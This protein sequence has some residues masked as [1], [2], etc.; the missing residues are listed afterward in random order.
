MGGVLPN[1]ASQGGGSGG[2]GNVTGPGSSTTNALARYS[3]ASGTTIKN[4]PVTVADDGTVTGALLS[5]AL[6][7]TGI[8]AI[9]RGGTGQ[10]TK[11]FVTPEQYGAIGDGSTDDSAAMQS[12]VDAG[13]LIILGPGKNYKIVTG[14][15]I[16][17]GG[18]TI[19]GSAVGGNNT[20]A[21]KSTIKYVGSGS[22]FASANPTTVSYPFITFENLIID[23]SGASGTN[24]VL[25]F[26]SC[27]FVTLNRV[28]FFGNGATNG[29]AVLHNVSSGKSSYYCTIKEC[30]F[31]THYIGVKYTNA[32]NSNVVQNTRFQP[33]AGGTGIWVVAANNISLVSNFFEGGSLGTNN[34]VLVDSSAVSVSIINSRFEGLANSIKI[35]A[36]AVNTYAAG[37]YYSGAAISDAGTASV[38]I[39]AGTA[40]AVQAG[41]TGQATLTNHGVLVGAGTAALTQ[42]AVGATKSV[43]QGTSGADP[44]FTTT[45]TVTSLTASGGP[46]TA[47]SAITGLAQF[48]GAGSALNNVLNGNTATMVVA[49]SNANALLLIEEGSTGHSCLVY[50]GFSTY[51]TIVAQDATTFNAGNLA[52]KIGLT[53]VSST[54]I[55]SINNQQGTTLN[56]IITSLSNN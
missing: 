51:L 36:G 56:F 27:A 29:I 40:I 33:I 44:A 47:S 32:A 24:P 26:T 11:Q 3:D 16:T 39:D 31:S 38:F 52:T 1:F 17:A 55:L 48:K 43:L 41:G 2:G 23:S 18:F 45:P 13:G 5:A 14:L 34:G 37:N 50:V 25:D 10:G 6:V 22:L 19:K 54:G 21:N 7:T 4:S 46:I 12:A 15:S 8:L 35:I 30:Y 9:A 20:S 28:F 53:Y 42:L 49:G